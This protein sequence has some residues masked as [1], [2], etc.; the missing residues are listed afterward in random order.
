MQ[1][2]LTDSKIYMLIFMQVLAHLAGDN[3]LYIQKRL[4]I[5]EEKKTV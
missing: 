3:G 4:G 2:D 5:R 1:A